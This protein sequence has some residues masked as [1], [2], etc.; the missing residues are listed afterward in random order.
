MGE[1][2]CGVCL[3][4]EEAREGKCWVKEGVESQ[5]EC[6][7]LGGVCQL[8]TNQLLD[9]IGREECW[10]RQVNFVHGFLIFLILLILLLLFFF[11]KGKVQY[12]LWR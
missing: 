8:L 2:G 9:G 7:A 5:E 11:F 3:S 6:N 10:E 1:E 12:P 4:G